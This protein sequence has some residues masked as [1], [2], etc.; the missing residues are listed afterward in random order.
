M[1][2]FNQ[3]KEEIIK[4]LNQLKE[5]AY[6]PNELNLELISV[7]PP[8]DPSHGEMSTNAAMVLAKSAGKNPRELADKLTEKLK[9]VEYIEEVSIAGPGFINFN[10]KPKVWQNQITKILA[11]GINYGDSNI[12]K[13]QKVNLE[14]VSANPTGPM[15]IGHSRGAVFGDALAGLLLKCGYDVIKEYYINDAGNQ[16][17]ILAK[18]A[19]LRYREANGEEI[20]EIPEGLYPG[21]YLVGV[22]QELKAKYGSSLLAK[23]EE[24]WLP[25]VKTTATS[26]MMELIKKDLEDLGIKH[27]VFFSELTLHKS[28]KIEKA[29]KLLEDKGLIYRGVLEP[30]KGKKIDDFEPKEQ[31]LFRSTSFGD[32]TDRVVKK[33]D[34]SYTY[35]AADI[36]Y[37]LDKI[38]RGADSLIFVL[39]A[40]HGGYVKRMKAISQALSDN[41]VETDIKICQL[42]NFIQD[43]Q[44]LKMSK[45]AGNYITVKDVVDLVGKD[46][47]RFIMLTRKNDIT[48]DFDLEK[49]KE[50]SKDNPVFYVQ[51]A[52]ARANSI[53]RNTLAEMPEVVQTIGDFETLNLASLNTK[54]ELSLIKLVASWPRVVE[55]A[56]IHHEPHRIAFYL[57]ELAAEF[58]SFWNKGREDTNLRFIIPENKD[59]STA[60]IALV[61]AIIFV[62]NSG[63]A[64]FNVEPMEEM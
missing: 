9:R 61:K 44:P 16:I 3:L 63:F 55:N 51:Y 48:L 33:S 12:G 32:D 53:L 15:H 27:D 8:R 18:S 14:Y 35:F 21:D 1:N 40:D 31:T 60:R 30:P 56:G 36:A 37:S 13:G 62:I 38:E 6:L 11:R 54:E 7:E 28:G 17:D 23:S 25:I 5:D 4:A 24:E 34:G 22:G 26:S 50:Q 58:H 57:Q 20:G 59:L 29:I 42:V 49:V 46:I 45:R 64:I 19:F 41:K 39:G 10:L 47:I 52:Y 43:G 2:I